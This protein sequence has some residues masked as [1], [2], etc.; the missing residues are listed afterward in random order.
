MQLISDKIFRLLLSIIMVTMAS[1]VA[2]AE[3]PQGL[4]TQPLI[5]RYQEGSQY[6]TLT[7]LNRQQPPV[8]QLIEKKA[9]QVQVVEFF[10]YGCHWCNQLEPYVENWL[11]TKPAN[12]TFVRIP[13]AFNSTWA[14]Y[15]KAYYVAESLGILDKIQQPL[16]DAI[17]KDNKTLST[18]ED[19]AKFF[20]DFGVDEAKFNDIFESFT[21]DRDM[22]WGQKLALAY[23]VNG[24]PTIIVNGPKR[25]YST[26]TAA[27]GDGQTLFN[28]IDFLIEKEMPGTVPIKPIASNLPAPAAVPPPSINP[29]I[30]KH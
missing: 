20:S 16:F 18:K 13:V 24:I 19:M 25:S 6:F 8:N 30:V 22:K 23:K 21:L 29:G 26:N 1:P 27:A 15:S 7:E 10:N 3:Q 5:S 28:V 14:N 2:A 11:K 12:V 4:P 9:Q 17:H